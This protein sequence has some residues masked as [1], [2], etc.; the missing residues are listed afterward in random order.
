MTPQDQTRTQEERMSGESR[1]EFE[2]DRAALGHGRPDT[3]DTTPDP[4]E[5]GKFIDPAA[6]NYLPDRIQRELLRCAGSNGRISVDYLFAI[7]RCG[8]AAERASHAAELTAKGAEIARIT[9]ELY[10]TG[11][12]T[13]GPEPTGSE[14]PSR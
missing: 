5:I 13:Q 2:L 9:Q 14:P 4:S 1:R 3:Q 6:E 8:Q 12:H 10:G 7:Y 11:A